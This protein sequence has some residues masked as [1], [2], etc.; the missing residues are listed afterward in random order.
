MICEF[1]GMH[2][3]QHAQPTLRLLPLLLAAA[4]ART[5]SSSADIR[6][7]AD[8]LSEALNREAVS[9]TRR[10]VCAASISHISAL[11]VRAALALFAARGGGRCFALATLQ[12]LAVAAMLHSG[13]EQW[14]INWHVCR[15]SGC[16]RDFLAAMLLWLPGMLL[17]IL[18]HPDEPRTIRLHG[19]DHTVI[20]RVRDPTQ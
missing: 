1:E 10:C 9:R 20:R 15:R 4:R 2:Q 8:G 18:T 12:L 11:P 19:L 6:S 14:Q 16:F 3:H 13:S 5:R 7:L 17:C